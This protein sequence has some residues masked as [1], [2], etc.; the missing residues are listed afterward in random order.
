MFRLLEKVRKRKKEI[1][2]RLD[3]YR[4]YLI[5]KKIKNKLFFILLYKNKEKSI[6]NVT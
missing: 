3:D 4:I 5:Y 6:Y 1:T 2:K